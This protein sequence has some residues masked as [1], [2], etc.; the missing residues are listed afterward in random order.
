MLLADSDPSVLTDHTDLGHWS[1]G[2]KRRARE[3]VS[4]GGMSMGFAPTLPAKDPC[5]NPAL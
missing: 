2:A 4:L 1:R 3:E 5:W